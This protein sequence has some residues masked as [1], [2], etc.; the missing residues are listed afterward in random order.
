MAYIVCAP[1]LTTA[2]GSHGPFLYGTRPCA[3]YKY[4]FKATRQKALKPWP[5]VRAR[6]VVTDAGLSQPRPNPSAGSSGITSFRVWVAGSD[7]RLRRSQDHWPRPERVAL[8]NSSGT[9]FIIPQ[10]IS[11]LVV[12]YSGGDAPLQ[13]PTP[14]LL[15]RWALTPSMTITVS[16]AFIDRAGTLVC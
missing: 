1:S 2:N 3:K 4:T 12:G 7:S 15:R 5:T 9:G 11:R 8:N 10:D 16:T 13:R 14:T 6:S